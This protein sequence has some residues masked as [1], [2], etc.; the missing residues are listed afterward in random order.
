MAAIRVK[1]WP[2]V[3]I[4]VLEVTDPDPVLKVAE[5]QRNGSWV[6]VKMM[7]RSLFWESILKGI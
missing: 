2:Q 6:V 7:V 5:E 3:G 4:A 1:L